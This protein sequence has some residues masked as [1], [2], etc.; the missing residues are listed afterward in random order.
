MGHLIY[1]FYTEKY[2]PLNSYYTELETTN[3]NLQIPELMQ[4]SILI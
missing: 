4:A 3:D 2:G 1:L